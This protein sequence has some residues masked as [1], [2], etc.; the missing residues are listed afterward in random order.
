[1]RTDYAQEILLKGF[2]AQ[3]QACYKSVIVSFLLDIIFYLTRLT[4]VVVFF[5]PDFDIFIY[6]VVG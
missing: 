4:L 2:S 5:F 3:R 1:M 6:M